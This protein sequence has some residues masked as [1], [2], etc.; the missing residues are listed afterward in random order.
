MMLHEQ[1]V[2]QE[3]CMPE[4]KKSHVLIRKLA[5]KFR[6][7]ANILLRSSKHKIVSVSSSSSSSSC[8][9]CP[10]LHSRDSSSIFSLTSWPE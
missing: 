2:S 6:K 4:F 7:F 1:L 3:E 9:M 8:P 10:L 5:H